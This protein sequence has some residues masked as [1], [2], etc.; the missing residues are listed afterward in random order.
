MKVLIL[1]RVHG[2]NHCWRIR[3]YP[4][5]HLLIP[6]VTCCLVMWLITRGCLFNT[7]FYLEF[8]WPS[9]RYS[10]YKSFI[11]KQEFCLL[12]LVW[13]SRCNFWTVYSESLVCWP[14]SLLNWSWILLNSVVNWT[15]ADCSFSFVT[16]M[17]TEYR[18]PSRTVQLILHLFAATGTCLSNRCL[19]MDY[20]A[21]IRCRG[22]VC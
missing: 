3:Y 8:P 11:H 10:L 14:V 5:R 12:V 21:S 6:H 2:R 15:G 4:T 13:S 16:S 1:S 22:N 19:A 9:N 18:S 20:S 17:R 7:A